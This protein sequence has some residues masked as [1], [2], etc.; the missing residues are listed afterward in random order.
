M[1]KENEAVLRESETHLFGKKFRS[2]ILEI[3]KFRKKFRVKFHFRKS[4]SN[5]QNKLYDGGKYGTCQS[6]FQ[7]NSGRKFQYGSS[8][9]QGKYL[10][11]KSK[12]DSFH[13]QLKTDT[14]GINDYD[15][16][17]NK[18]IIYR[19]NNK[20]TTGRKAISVCKTVEKNYM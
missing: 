4:P 13:Q 20:C 1:L 8:S 14:T 15:T 12:G 16:S 17:S 7:N 11:R 6:P 10:F 19:R 3:E 5:S 9:T 18:K 2:H